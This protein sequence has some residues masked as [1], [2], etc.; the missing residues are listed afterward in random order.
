[1][2]RICGVTGF[3][4]RCCGTQNQGTVRRDRATSREV[5]G[6]VT[7]LTVF[8]F[9]GASTFFLTIGGCAIFCLIA[10]LFLKEPKGSFADMHHDEMESQSKDAGAVTAMAG[11]G[12]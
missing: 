6:A 11:A 10:A 4:G 7:F 1:M 12:S 9:V 5:V 2:A 3:E 8:S